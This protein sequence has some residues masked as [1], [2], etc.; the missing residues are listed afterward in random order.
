ADRPELGAAARTL[1]EAVLRRDRAGR[2]AAVTAHG[3]F[4]PAQ[5]F[6]DGDAGYLVDL[7]RLCRTHP[8]LDVANFRVGLAAPLVAAGRGRGERFTAASR[9]RGGAALAALAVHE[10]FCDL[11]RAIVLWRKRPP[12]WERDCR[13]ALE[14]GRARL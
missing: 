2:G 1:L 13:A 7:D 9:A 4:G 14:R 8:A 11:R 5:L 10:A 12:D 6:V 3:D